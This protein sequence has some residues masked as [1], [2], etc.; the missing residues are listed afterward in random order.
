MAKI[1]AKFIRYGVLTEDAQGGGTYGQMKTPGKA[2]TWKVD[3]SNNDQKLFADDAVDL[4]D[5]SFQSGSLTIGLNRF[6]L[7]TQADLLGASI[8][9]GKLVDSVNDMPPYVGIGVILT[10]QNTNNER[11]YRVKFLKKVKFSQPSD[12]DKTQGESVEFGTYELA[13]TVMAL[14]NG[15]WRD[16]EDFD[17]EAEAVT[18][19]E[20]HFTSGGGA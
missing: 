7:A 5:T 15:E 9:D 17:T 10:L 4:V 6:D 1:G 12:D 2:I 18:A 3:V 19:L 14:P 11:K 20:A 16:S 8:V 13:A